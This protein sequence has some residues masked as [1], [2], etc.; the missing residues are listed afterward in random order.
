M[1][2]QFLI[3]GLLAA[4]LTGCARRGALLL[5]H[6]AET[7]GLGV[8]L[9][10]S[11][12]LRLHPDHRFEYTHWTDM[13]GVGQQGRGTYALRGQQLRLRFDG[14]L[15]AP[16]PLVEPQLLPGLPA[17]DSVAVFVTL[18]YGQEV[19]AGLTLL[20]VDETGRVLAGTSSNAAGQ[21]RLAVART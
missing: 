15:S 7:G 4:G 2:N 17:S 14:G 8:A 12:E 5:G 13:V 18:R 20:A 10:E 9:L 16:V 11:K 21:A 1:K 3:L 6:Y 19:A